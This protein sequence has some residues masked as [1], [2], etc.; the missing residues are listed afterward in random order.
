MDFLDRGQS[1]IED[2]LEDRREVPIKAK[3]KIDRVLLQLSDTPL[4]VRPLASNLDDYPGIV[5]IRI[6]YMNV[7]YRLLGFRAPSSVSLQFCSQLKNRATPSTLETLQR[8]QNV[9][10]K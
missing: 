3:A 6:L 10:W 5:E 2:W 1:P 4:W 8:R 7:Q 9:E